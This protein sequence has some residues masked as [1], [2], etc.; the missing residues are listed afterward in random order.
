VEALG[1]E[2]GPPPQLVGQYMVLETQD[3]KG[4]VLKGS[5]LIMSGFCR[6]VFMAE[7]HGMRHLE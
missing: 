4:R 7:H 5:H 3:P 2:V 1:R 6:D